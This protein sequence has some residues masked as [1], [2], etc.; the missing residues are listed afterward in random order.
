M[1][2]GNFYNYVINLRTYSSYKINDEDRPRK[3]GCASL[4]DLS[5]H[6][7][8]DNRHPCI[9]NGS[10]YPFMISYLRLIYTWAKM[11]K[12]IAAK[13]AGT[14]ESSY[15]ITY[16]ER[17]CE[18]SRLV[19]DTLDRCY[20]RYEHIVLYYLVKL[21]QLVA[22]QTESCRRYSK[23]YHSVALL[24]FTSLH[25]GDEHLAH[26]LMSTVL[27]HTHYLVEGRI[28]DPEAIEL[29]ELL[30]VSDTSERTN[31]CDTMRKREPNRGV[32]LRD[33]YNSLPSIRACY[34]SSFGG[35]TQTIAKSRN[36]FTVI[37][38]EI[39]TFILPEFSGSLVPLD[40]MYL[41]LLHFYNQA[42]KNELLGQPVENLPSQFVNGVTNTLRMIY[43]LE[44][45]RPESVNHISMS[46]K[47]T[48]L[49]CVFLT[50]NDLFLEDTVHCY[51]LALLKLYFQPSYLDRLELNSPIPGV[52][53]FYDF[54]MVFVV[55]YGGV[56][57]GDSLFATFM[58]LPLQQRYNIEFRKAIWGEHQHVIR[59]ITLKIDECLLPMHR[60]LT[61][62]ESHVELLQLYLSALVSN[63]VKST[64]SPVLYLIAVCHVN[65]F[66]FSRHDNQDQ[67]MMKRQFIMLKQVLRI[68][69]QELLQHLLYYKSYN[70][71]ASLG[72]DLYTELPQD[73]QQ[74][75]ETL[76]Y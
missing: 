72:F 51:L 23:L 35:M 58:L 62:Q 47:I 57:F 43:M 3:T 33:S 67:E 63:V 44:T 16:L 17:T 2:S 4:P 8:D 74:L 28:G 55:Q 45:W 32:L 10:P 24:L 75:L 50:G 34:M 71:D 60:Y 49:M 56:S 42:S 22:E 68:Q 9:Q 29:A 64:W 59:A 66:L 48:R 1:K 65:G 13:F 15:V 73:R 69:N 18:N 5:G 41:P 26:D 40:W 36:L 25:S 30:R 7:L 37:P 27:F 70:K 6:P 52:A 53:S 46:A 38:H 61:P 20:S 31:T 11:H 21:Y 76:Q 12:G 54:Y 19:G 39:E 14:I